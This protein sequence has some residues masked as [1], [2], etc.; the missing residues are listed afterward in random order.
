MTTLLLQL[1]FLFLLVFYSA[2]Q[3]ENA[4]KIIRTEIIFIV[5]LVILTIWIG[6]TQTHIPSGF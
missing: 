3:F 2:Y 6:F 4:L 5:G 1:L